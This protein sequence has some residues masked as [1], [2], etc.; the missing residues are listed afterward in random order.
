MIDGNRWTKDTARRLL[1]KA[2]KELMACLGGL[3]E[4]DIEVCLVTEKWTVRDVL[5]HI[6][7]WEE[8]AVERLQF[9]LDGRAADICYLTPAEYDAWNERARRASEKWSTRDVLERLETS[10]RHLLK[11]VETM[12]DGQLNEASVLSRRWSH[13]RE[14]TAQI[15]RWREASASEQVVEQS[16]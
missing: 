5:V 8:V 7:V 14:H 6:Q 10:H 15:C 9:I 4:E 13:E 16:D 12:T 1:D 2:R 3:T 11:L